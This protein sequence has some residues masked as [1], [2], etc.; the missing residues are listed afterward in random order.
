MVAR[1]EMSIRHIKLLLGCAALVVCGGV[2]GARQA[3]AGPVPVEYVVVCDRYGPGWYYVPGDP[4]E[5]CVNALTGETR[6][7]VNGKTVSVENR[8]D[9]AFQGAAISLA[10]PTPV[11]GD[12][13]T[14]A[15]AG[16]LGMYESTKAFGIAAAVEVMDGLSISGGLS[17]GADQYSVGKRA[18]FNFSW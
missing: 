18:G 13:K 7:E 16:K 11:I 14:F 12:G 2:L 5:T 15:L 10:M 4:D 9:Y 1:G 8:M 17:F 6:K 3:A